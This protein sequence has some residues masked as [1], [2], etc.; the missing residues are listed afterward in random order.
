MIA[1]ASAAQAWRKEAIVWQLLR[2]PHVVPFLGILGTQT[3]LRLVST[4][5]MNGRLTDYLSLHTAERPPR[6]VISFDVHRMRVLTYARSYMFWPACDISIRLGW[7]TATSKACVASA[8][9]VAF[10]E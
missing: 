9:C 5:M 6:F 3:N 10:A 7:C 1:D 4:W 8:P 2:H